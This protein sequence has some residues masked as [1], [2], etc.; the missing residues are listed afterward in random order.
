MTSNQLVVKRWTWNKTLSEMAI[1]HHMEREG[2]ETQRWKNEP[3]T[4]YQA[5][6]YNFEKVILIMRG[7]ITYRLPE[8][9][10]QVSLNPGDRLVLPAGLKHEAVVGP[11]GVVCLEGHRKSSE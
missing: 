6:A 3:G 4:K 7:S 9:G 11:M 5:Q 2:L 8:T 1:L 10:E